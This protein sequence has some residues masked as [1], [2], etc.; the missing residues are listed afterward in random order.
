[1]CECSVVRLEKAAAIAVIHDEPA[2]SE[3]IL[4]YL[5]SRNNQV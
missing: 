2:F 3:L 1:M 5:I 4:R